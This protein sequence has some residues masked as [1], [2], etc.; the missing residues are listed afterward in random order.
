MLSYGWLV[1]IL[2]TSLESFS[3]FGRTSALSPFLNDLCHDLTLSAAQIGGAYALANL[4]SGTASPFIGRV[5]D[6]TTPARF[7]VL[8]TLFFGIAFIGLSMLKFTQF[9]SFFNFLAF[10]LGFT[11]IRI[12][13]HAYMVAGHSLIAVW[14]DQYRGLA[15][16][17]SCFLLSTIASMMPWIN[18][19]LHLL[20]EWQQIWICIG[21]AWLIIPTAICYFIKNPQIRVIKQPKIKNAPRQNLIKNPIYWL[22]ILALFFKAFQN[23]GIAFHLFPICNELGA[24]PEL[25]SL[26]FIIISLISCTIIF[27]SGYFFNFIGIRYSILIFL[28]SDCLFLAFFKHI[29]HINAVYGF[30]IFSGFYWGMNQIIAYLVIPRIFGVKNIGSINGLTIG[31]ICFGSSMGPFVIGL[32][33]TYYSYNIIINILIFIAFGLLIYGLTLFRRMKAI[34]SLHETSH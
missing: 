29:Q 27:I 24:K 32:A 22:I 2:I 23:T 31:A 4:F 14:F 15:T 26:S 9:N 10:T 17:I 13:V 7:L 20:F 6:K 19:R 11:F 1:L 34:D 5:Y 8:H 21:L 33:K 30:V 16:G 12:T 18:F 28:L 3:G 25:I